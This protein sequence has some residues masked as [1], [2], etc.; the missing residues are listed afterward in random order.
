MRILV[1]GGAGYIGGT[2]SYEALKREHQILVLD[3]FSNS[4]PSQ[5]ESLKHTFTN[6]FSFEKV[7]LALEESKLQKIFSDFKPEIVV[8]FAGLKSVSESQEQPIRYWHN[9]VVSTANLL[10]AMVESNTKKIVFSSSATVYGESSLQ[11]IP[12]TA[13][14]KSM[15]VY[16]S[17]KIAIEEML[18][19]AAVNSIIDVVSL[20][21]FNPV[22]AHKEKVIFENPFDSPNNI[23]PRII[24]VALGLDE[25][26][27]IYGNDYPTND[28]SGERDYIHI[29][30][31]V[32]GHFA[33][34][35]FIK[36]NSGENIF[37]LGTGTS[38]SV[39]HLIKTFES[40]NA[41]KIP[42]HTTERRKG[43]VAICYA[44][45]IKAEKIL[46]WKTKYT[47][48]EMCKDAWE[49]IKDHGLN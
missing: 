1:T 26:L 35:D 33:A 43:D 2:F 47:L 46:N 6:N 32:S 17:T 18:S 25:K 12:E 13:E 9:N 3:N 39:H 29:L 5:I 44:D 40:V 45:P 28:G 4:K 42:Y 15:S 10:K 37:N 21:Y 30:D 24:R 34:M 19:D 16:G 22:G 38:T 23:M 36:K 49:G 11:P 41:V 7:D 31:L 8:H 14:I 48:N 20:R 27:Q